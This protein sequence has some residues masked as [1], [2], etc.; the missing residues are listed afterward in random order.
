MQKTLMFSFTQSLGR[1]ETFMFS[2]TLQQLE[3]KF[4]SKFHWLR[5]SEQHDGVALCGGLRV[6]AGTEQFLRQSG[7]KAL[8][9]LNEVRICHKFFFNFSYERRPSVA[10]C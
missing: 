5:S 9:V 1:L 4:S 2:C 8:P 6:S 7:T 3:P 10:I